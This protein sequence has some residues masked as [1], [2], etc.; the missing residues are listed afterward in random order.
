MNV[1]V[2]LRNF[3]FLAVI[4]FLVFS[5]SAV[6][7]DQHWKCVSASAKDFI[8]HLLVVDPQERMSSSEALSHSWLNSPPTPVSTSKELERSSLRNSEKSA[9]SSKSNKSNRSGKSLRSD[10]GRVTP[11]E[12]DELHRDPEIQAELSSH[13]GSRT[14]STSSDN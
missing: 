8:D 6:C 1:E 2:T 7:F 4:L 10:R 12:I 11:E 5:M 9:K 13:A 14:R 3:R